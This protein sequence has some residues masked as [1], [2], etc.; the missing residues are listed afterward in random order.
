VSAALVAGVVAGYGVALP[1]GAI[2][3]YLVGLGARERMAIAG[4]AALGV[5][6]T[7]GCY[8]LAAALGGVG[9]EQLL[10]PVTTALRV[11]AVVGLV[12]L[13]A[14]TISVAVRR[15][16]AA[17]PTGAVVGPSPGPMRAF[18][19]LLVLTAL[20]PTTLGYFAAL[21]LGREGSGTERSVAAA[22]T[23]AFGVFAAS[24]SWQLLL[25]GSGAALRRFLAGPRSQLGIAVASGVIMLVLAALLALS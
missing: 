7:D 17:S 10:R 16:R 15:Y 13:A 12:L 14:R 18:V 23:F 2:G 19:T 6:T 22:A 24:A 1:L 8:A 5:A 11:A 20:N 9:L 4:A 3:S 25:V 21:V